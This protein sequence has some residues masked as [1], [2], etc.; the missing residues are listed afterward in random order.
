MIAQFD[1]EVDIEVQYRKPSDKND[2]VEVVFADP[3]AASKFDDKIYELLSKIPGQYVES[4]S[5]ACMGDE[6]FL[7][8]ASLYFVEPEP[9]A[10]GEP[11]G[12]P[13]CFFQDSWRRAG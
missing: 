7:W 8:P 12:G 10:L 6:G 9:E 13:S 5:K 11:C 3:R 4:K 1:S 2:K